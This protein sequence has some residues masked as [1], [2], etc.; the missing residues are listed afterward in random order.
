MKT[1]FQ[2]SHPTYQGNHLWLACLLFLS[3]THMSSPEAR[4][5]PRDE[6]PSVSE[7]LSWQVLGYMW[8]MTD[9]LALSGAEWSVATQTEEL[10]WRCAPHLCDPQV[11]HPKQWFLSVLEDWTNSS[12]GFTAGATACWLICTS[13]DGGDMEGAQ[14]KKKE[15][16][17]RPHVSSCWPEVPSV[18]S[19]WP[20]E[21][22]NY[23]ASTLLT[24]ESTSLSLLALST[25]W[26]RFRM[27]FHPDPIPPPGISL[28]SR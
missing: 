12:S 15:Q 5:T 22:Q 4:G 16:R 2:Q 3:H 10:W 23:Q 9:A 21:I 19:A 27:T 8:A 11:F 28:I 13:S 1:C 14:K 25:R 17:K 26:L 18:R 20:D 7:G 6:S 24:F